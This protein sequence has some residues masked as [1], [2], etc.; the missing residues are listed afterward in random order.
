VVVGAT[1]AIVGLQAKAD[2]LK[3]KGGGGEIPSAS[4]RMRYGAVNPTRTASPFALATGL[5]APRFD[6]LLEAPPARAAPAAAATI[7][8]W[9]GQIRQ[10]LGLPEKA[11]NV[12]AV[13][14]WVTVQVPGTAGAGDYEGSLTVT[15]QGAPPVTVPVQLHVADWTLPDVKDYGS[16]LFVYQSPDTLAEYYKV[17]PW[18]PAHWRLID[19]SLTLLGEASN[20]GL[21]LPL[22]AESQHGNAESLVLWIKKADGTYAYDFTNFDKYVETALKHHD[23]KRLKAVELD[24]WGR[25]AEVKDAGALVTLLD[26]AT[27]AKSQMKL[28]DYGTAEC[29]ALWRPLLLAVRER[30]QKAGVAD[31]IMLGMPTDPAPPP[32][33]VAMFRNI[34]PDAPWMRED[35]HAHVYWRDSAHPALPYDPAECD[36]LGYDRY[37]MASCKKVVPVG[38]TSTVYGHIIW[39]G[40]LPDPKRQRLYGWRREPDRPFILSYNRCQSATLALNGFASPWPYH[41][42]MESSL[43]GGWIG[44]GRVGGDYFRMGGGT[45]FLRYPAS[46]P[47]L[48]HNLTG[49]TPDLLAPGPDGA[50]TTVRF[51]N[52]RAG[53]Q[54]SE[55]RIFLEKALLNKDKPLPADLAKR[56]Q[57]LL[58]ARTRAMQTGN[59]NWTWGVS[60]RGDTAFGMQDWQ[61]SCRSLFDLAAEAAKVSQAP[62]AAP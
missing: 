21:I 55:A 40:P 22:M 11:E 53:I 36:A 15:A 56:C 20:A 32:S 8:G 51:E 58:D 7:A 10:S 1:A 44:N 47:A 48:G 17:A 2:A 26:P 31:K 12:A 16:V 3:K 27:G 62:A 23:P 14:V 4:W 61:K 5:I 34:L 39:Y 24:V 19:R 49:S 6:M 35:H 13:P 28:P 52:A 50:V 45:L 18:S 29:E 59:L 43:V 37:K 33:H 9:S 60:S 25:Q 41:M 38:L 57:E 54:E 46:V 42:W 30:L